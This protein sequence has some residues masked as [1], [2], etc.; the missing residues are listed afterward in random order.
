MDNNLPQNSEI[1][2]PEEKLLN[3]KFLLNAAI[4][5][6]ALIIL[7]M[8]GLSLKLYSQPTG[9]GYSE[10]YLF[11]NVGARPISMAGAYTAI[12][13]E[14]GALFYNPAGLGYFSPEPMIN[15]SVTML[16]L[17]RTHTTLSWGQSISEGLG[18]GLA[19]NGFYSGSFTARDIM[20][21]EIGT[22]SDFQYSITGGAAYRLEFASMGASLK[23]LTNNLIGSETQAT[24]FAF[25]VGTKFDVM[26]LFSVGVAV[27]N[28]SGMMFWNNLNEDVEPIPYT[29]RA[30]IAMEYGLNEDEYVTRSTVT[31]ELEKVF[32]PATRYVLVGIDA[33]MTQHQMSPTFIIGTE[34]V[35]HEIIAFRGGIAI[36]GDNMGEPQ[37]FPMTYWGGG[38]SLR[39]EIDL[40]LP[41]QTNI[42]YTISND[43]LTQSGISHHITLMFEFINQTQQ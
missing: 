24:G 13:N 25:D 21:H 38:I 26:N 37:L 34:A 35:V 22:Y 15:S 27:Q 32:V 14:P 18:V 3:R 16:D 30:G 23:Y 5:I 39:P 40:G 4:W 31:G 43:H 11:R 41:F 9:G 1:H 19:L 29:V 8:S 28:I 36:Y 33:V 10:A 17:G 42:D 12:V 7:L 20:G 6:T 2:F